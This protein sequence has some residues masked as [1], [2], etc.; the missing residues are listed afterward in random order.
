M[1]NQDRQAIEDLFVRLSDVERQAPPRD[2]EAERFIRDRIGRQPAAPYLMAQTIVVQEQALQEAQRRIQE[3]E[4]GATERQGRGLFSSVPPVPRPRAS[5][6]E[7]LSPAQAGRG[8]F[9]AGAAQTAMGVAGGVLLGNFI[10]GLFGGHEAQAAESSAEAEQD[11]EID[12]AG[13]EDDGGG[14]FDGGD[15][16]I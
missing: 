1:D 15:G 3:L 8:G 2:P 11:S 6:P 5:A 16:E 4:R 7:S 13:H 12:A 10:A 9:L 14:F